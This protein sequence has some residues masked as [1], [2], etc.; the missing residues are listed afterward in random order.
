MAENFVSARFSRMQEKH[1][2]DD[3]LKISSSLGYGIA[4]ERLHFFNLYHT[5]HIKKK[6][7][8][9]KYEIKR[10]RSGGDKEVNNRH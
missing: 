7:G 3:V 5:L 1:S 10:K 4:V 2:H 8:G 6:N 9:K